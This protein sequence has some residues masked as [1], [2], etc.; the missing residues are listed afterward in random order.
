MAAINS[1][2]VIRM[3]IIIHKYCEG[4]FKHVFPVTLSSYTYQAMNINACVCTCKCTYVHMNK[5]IDIY[6]NSGR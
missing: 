5:M 3:F 2:V 6:C 1:S 4:R